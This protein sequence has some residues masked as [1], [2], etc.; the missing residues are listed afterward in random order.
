MIKQERG[1]QN[2]KEKIKTDRMDGAEQSR[3]EQS[4]A[5]QSRVDSNK[6]G[7]NSTELYHN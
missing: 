3:A 4:R 6:I 2:I 5:E 7:H 1:K